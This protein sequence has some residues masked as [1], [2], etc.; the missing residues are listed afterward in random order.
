MKR[1]IIVYLAEGSENLPDWFEIEQYREDLGVNAV[2]L[3][4]S[5]AEV[6]YCWWQLA[7][8]GMHHISCLRAGYDETQKN[9]QFRGEPLRLLG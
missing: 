3:A 5:E 2:C 7:A 9:I 8:R 6:H 1:G 4:I